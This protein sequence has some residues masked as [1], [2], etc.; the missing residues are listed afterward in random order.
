MCVIV[1]A[2]SEDENE[3]NVYHYDVT[4]DNW[5]TLPPSGHHQGILCVVDNILCIFG[6]LT[7]QVLRKIST[8]TRH[9]AVV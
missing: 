9:Y 3:N 6:G 4:I 1:C 2:T 7:D 8:Y 5:S